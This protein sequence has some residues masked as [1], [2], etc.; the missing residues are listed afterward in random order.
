MDRGLIIV[1]KIIKEYPD[2]PKE[3]IKWVKGY[4]DVKETETSPNF[5]N[6][7]V[8][9]YITRIA[10]MFKPSWEEMI[11]TFLQSMPNIV[12]EKVKVKESLEDYVV[13]CLLARW[14]ITHNSLDFLIKNAKRIILKLALLYSS[15]DIEKGFWEVIERRGNLRDLVLVTVNSSNPLLVAKISEILRDIGVIAVRTAIDEGYYNLLTSRYDV[16]LKFWE[17]LRGKEREDECSFCKGLALH[18]MGRIEEAIKEYDKAIGMNLKEPIYRFAKA[19]ALK[20]I[21]KYHEALIEL[22]E[23]L[24]MEPDN[25]ELNLEKAILMS[26]TE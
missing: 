3:L 24:H 1:N 9:G 12:R 2:V 17:E 13:D 4:L 16:S 7:D 8:E 18:K 25:Y 10:D 21:G 15:K 5:D 22:N 19:L 11:N 23:A 26:D 14:A 20:G 6:E